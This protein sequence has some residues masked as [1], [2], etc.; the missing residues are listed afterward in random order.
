MTKY[1]CASFI[2]FSTSLLAMNNGP[3]PELVRKISSRSKLVTEGSPRKSLNGS[4]RC[5]L[6]KGLHNLASQI[7]EAPIEVFLRQS[8]LYINREDDNLVISAMMV[9]DFIFDSWI[10][11]AVI[12]KYFQENE[13]HNNVGI[14]Q[15]SY[16]FDENQ[17]STVKHVFLDYFSLSAKNNTYSIE[18]R[19][20]NIP[21][22]DVAKFEQKIKEDIIEEYFISYIEHRSANNS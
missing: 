17:R 2:V 13:W 8:K 20:F 6:G 22:E 11:K 7:F 4:L 21:Q 3:R 1:L 15:S 14:S 16:A 10:P 18:K 9:D 12:A 19:N 5:K